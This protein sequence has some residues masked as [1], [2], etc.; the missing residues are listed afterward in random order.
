MVSDALVEEV[1]ARADLVE[2]CGEHM[3]LKRVG[4]SY[5][6]PCP[7]HG[8]EGANFS[9]DSERGIFKCFVCGEG[10]D[11]FSFLMLH[12]GLDFP[13]A[14]RHV[15]ERVGVE[16]P[17][18][19]DRR[20]DPFAGLR[21]VNAFAEEWFGE[22]L[23]SPEGSRARA[24]LARRGIDDPTSERFGIGFAPGEWRGLRDAARERGVDEEALLEVGLLATSDRAAEPYDRFRNRVTFSIRD[25]RDRPIGF[26]GRSLEAG[27][28]DTPKYINSPDSP[29]FEKGELLY[30][31]NVAR[32]PMRRAKAAV[33]VEGFMDALA[34]HQHG[35]QHAVAPLGTAL[36]TSQAGQLG[37]YA[38][39]AYL[40][41][42][43]DKPGRKASFKAADTLLAAGVH[44]LIVTLPP[45]ED[46]DSLVRRHGRESFAALLDDAMDALELKLRILEE[47]GY[48]ETAE[49]RRRA[50][51]GLLSTLRAVRDPALQDIYI[52]R[53][54]EK[55]GVRRET[56]VHEVAREGTR[57]G[58]RRRRTEPARP[59]AA[60]QPDGAK[61]AAERSLLLLLIRDSLLT[62]GSSERSWIG[63]ALD[64]GVRVEH[65][66]APKYRALYAALATTHEEGTRPDEADLFK[67]VPKELRELLE[68][69]LG[70]ATEM[71]HPE[72]IYEASV[73]RLIYRPAELRLREIRREMKMADEPQKRELLQEQMRIRSG[74]PESERTRLA[75]VL[76]WL[77]RS[78]NSPQEE[79]RGD[80]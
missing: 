46:P 74:L 36:T 16:I 40:V 14:V 57:R 42:D 61:G 20:P 48:L 29:I 53:A 26:G 24:Y 47:K 21:E 79:W 23:R 8:G 65:F 71:T 62:E 13:S 77:E 7:L 72:E 32:H 27:E 52:G 10:G 22:R 76:P 73:Q 37:R 66:H 75:L 3:Q 59:A 1:R 31:L 44:P 2:I 54:T 43:S 69:L 19:E 67:V 18:A 60:A 80:G 9:V 56:I 6:G 28:E 51:D 30:L 45:G 4:K 68:A 63:R 64:D 38:P 35:F 50:L 39:Q 70:D 78:A 49:G 34:L 15:A 11:V 55:T 58:A 5:R 17:D 25:L 33:V 41:Y 12:L